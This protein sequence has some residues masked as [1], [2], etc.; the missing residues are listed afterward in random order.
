MDYRDEYR[1]KLI[2]AGEAAGLVKS[3][4]SIKS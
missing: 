3:G 2:S 4:M 1:R